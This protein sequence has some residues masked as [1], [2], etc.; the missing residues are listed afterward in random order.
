[1]S[2]ALGV[3]IDCPFVSCHFAPLGRSCCTETDSG[4]WDR[5]RRI[6]VKAVEVAETERGTNE[7][8]LST[9]SACNYRIGEGN[10]SFLV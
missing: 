2:F 3:R 9:D 7:E 10:L 1:M 6:V 5:M 4:R 8:T